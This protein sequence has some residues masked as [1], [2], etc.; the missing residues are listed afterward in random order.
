MPP[1]DQT[2]DKMDRRATTTVPEGEPIIPNGPTATTQDIQEF[3]SAVEAMDYSVEFG[4]AS[5]VTKPKESVVHLT[6]RCTVGD[7][8]DEY[9][10]IWNNSQNRR[11]MFLRGNKQ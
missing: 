2:L 4:E 3:K 9:L 7:L 8:T 5:A 1:R 10:H 11:G 6:A